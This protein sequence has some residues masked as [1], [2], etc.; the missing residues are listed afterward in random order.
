MRDRLFCLVERVTRKLALLTPLS[1]PSGRSQKAWG[2]VANVCDPSSTTKG[3]G[4]WAQIHAGRSICVAP[5]G[6]VES[7]ESPPLMRKDSDRPP[8]KRP[9]KWRA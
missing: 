7:F 2:S 8:F 3:L 6:R 4:L 9:G 5:G 1:A